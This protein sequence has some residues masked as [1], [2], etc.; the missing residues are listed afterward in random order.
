METS[1]YLYESLRTLDVSFIL[2]R[3]D[4]CSTLLAGLPEKQLCRITGTRKFD[5]ITAILKVT[6]G[7]N[8]KMNHLKLGFL[9]YYKMN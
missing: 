7:Q 6:L 5:H 1:F 2:S 9:L 8:C 3:I 4:Y